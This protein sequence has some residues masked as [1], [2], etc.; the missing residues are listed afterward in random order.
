MKKVTRS[1]AIHKVAQNRASLAPD[2]DHD[3]DPSEGG[4]GG[5]DHE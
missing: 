4:A 5:K 3:P 1:A 2:P